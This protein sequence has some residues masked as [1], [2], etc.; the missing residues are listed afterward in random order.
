MTYVMLKELSS[1]HHSCSSYWPWSDTEKD[2]IN[3]INI[4]SSHFVQ[5]DLSATEANMKLQQSQLAK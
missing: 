4:H 5:K 2:E 3:I 1:H